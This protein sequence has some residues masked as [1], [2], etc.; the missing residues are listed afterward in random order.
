MVLLTATPHKGDPA[1]FTLFLQ[2]LDP[3]TFAD[4]QSIKRV[5]EDRRA[6][7][8]LRRLKEAMVYFPERQLDGTWAARK[9]FTKRLPRTVRFAI[10]G[11]EFELYRAVTRFVKSQSARAAARAEVDTRARALGFLMALFQRRL[12]S[13]AWALRQSLDR[14]ANLIEKKVERAADLAR[15]L[16]PEIPDEEDLEEMDE[17]E[18][19]QWEE[20]L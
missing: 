18:R 5:M 9:I 10:D 17:A 11:P 16:P 20:K 6:P 8:Y 19:G 4:V 13:S 7:F 3:D 12:A 15:E 2:L 1:N 14:R